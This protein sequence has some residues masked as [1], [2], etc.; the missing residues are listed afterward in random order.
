MANFEKL[1]DNINDIL[2]SV[3]NNQDLCKYI[4]LPNPVGQP[5][6]VNT[7]ELLFK[8]IFPLPRIPDVNETAANF[9]NLYFADFQLGDSNSGVKTGVLRF[10][11]LCHIDLWRITGHS[12]LRPLIILREIDQMI[13][14]QRIIGVKKAKFINLAPLF[15]NNKYM[16]YRVNY[17]I[18]SGN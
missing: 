7:K 12:M 5:D 13:N 18:V 9:L 14:N 6:I 10:E 4:H 15:A 2:V 8:K 3:T 1:N 16:G 11:V 17:E